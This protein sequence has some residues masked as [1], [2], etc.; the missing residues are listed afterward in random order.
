MP[1]DEAEEA[2]ITSVKDLEWGP[3]RSHPVLPK[4]L[5]LKEYV[6]DETS[7]IVTPDA[8]TPALA[9]SS[10]KACSLI[11]W[12]PS[13]SNSA[14]PSTNSGVFCETREMLAGI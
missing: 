5:V 10:M 1:G 3:T 14:C 6:P 12:R 2:V 8:F 9:L 11:V 4:S 7:F 13:A